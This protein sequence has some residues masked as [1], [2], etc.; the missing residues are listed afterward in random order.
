MTALDPSRIRREAL[1]WYLLLAT[2]HARP[3][4]ICE[5]I[6]EATL[7]S[8]YPDTTAME[9]RQQLDY[10]A[11]RKLADLRKEPSGRWWAQLS[12]IGIDLV[13]YTVDC[14]PG[15]ARPQKYWVGDE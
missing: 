3:N 8:V 7:R 1:R 6:L 4:E 15:I 9:I 12:A 13:E 2:Y 14:L 10:L 5:S 11:H